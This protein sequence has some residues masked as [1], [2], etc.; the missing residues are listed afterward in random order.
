MGDVIPLR[1]YTPAYG[2]VSGTSATVRA[3]RPSP[4]HP[5]GRRL[6]PAEHRAAAPAHG[7]RRTGEPRQAHAPRQGS[8]PHRS[9][10]P[11][12]S[13]APHQ[14][15]ARQAHHPAT[16]RSALADRLGLAGLRLTRR[17]RAVLVLLAM[18]LVAPMVTWGATAVASAPGEP[19]EVRV[20]AVQPGETLW[21]FAQE[22]AEPGEDVRQAVARLQ[23][24]NEMSSATVRVG[25]LLLLPKE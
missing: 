11:R 25:E 4:A 6:A 8:A 2:Q 19:T 12:E 1:Q 17:G 9:H 10:A 21:G 5:A 18:L 13:Y 15:Y 23:D 20:H 14:A 3:Y 16:D 7:P 24:L 22:V